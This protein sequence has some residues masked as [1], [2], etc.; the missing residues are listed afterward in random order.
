[1][2]LVDRRTDMLPKLLTENLCSLRSGVDRLAFSV[3]WTISLSTGSILS[4]SF[5]KTVI[6]SKRAYTYQQAQQ[7]IDD[8]TDNS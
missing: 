3:I 7:A 4:T 1:V 2:Y 6:N 8:S 5:H